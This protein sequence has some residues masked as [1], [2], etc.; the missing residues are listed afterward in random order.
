MIEDIGPLVH[1]SHTLKEFDFK[2][3]KYFEEVENDETKIEQDY[4]EDS[5]ERADK[6]ANDHFDEDFGI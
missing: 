5:D 2:V 6:Y 4:D 1:E 3:E